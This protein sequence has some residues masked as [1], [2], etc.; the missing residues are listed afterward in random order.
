VQGLSDFKIVPTPY[1]LD[2]S[3]Q[4]GRCLTPDSNNLL[5]LTVFSFGDLY[6]GQL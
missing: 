1:F 6:S 4:D 2:G 3:S 5:N